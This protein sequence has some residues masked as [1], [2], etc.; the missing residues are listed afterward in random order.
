V[1]NPAPVS[2]M[3]K[4]IVAGENPGLPT[5]P[6]WRGRRISRTRLRHGVMVFLLLLVSASWVANTGADWLQ[7]TGYALLAL[8]AVP[9]GSSARFT[10]AL[11]RT[12]LLLISVT[13]LISLLNGGMASKGNLLFI[14]NILIGLSCAYVIGARSLAFAETY[15]GIVLALAMVSLALFPLIFLTDSVLVQLPDMLIKPSSSE[16]TQ[17]R[18][19]YT[20]LG[21]S[22]F[23]TNQTPSEIWRNQ[24][25]FWEP[26]MFGFMLVIALAFS[27]VL[28]ESRRRRAVYV[29][30]IVMTFAPGAYALLLFYLGLWAFS[31]LRKGVLAALV[32]SGLF[33]T[34][35]LLFIPLLREVLLVLF[36][37]DIYTDNSIYI[38]ITDLWLPYVVA[39]Q[40]PFWGYS[41]MV[42]YQD[43]MAIAIERRMDGM[44]NSFGAYFYRYGY[45]WAA[46]MFGVIAGGVRRFGPELGLLLPVLLLGIMY[47][48]IGFSPLFLALVFVG[49]NSSQTLRQQIAARG[50]QQALAENRQGSG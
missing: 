14:I 15:N 25:I 24:S 16:I 39:L 32:L 23:S 42:P 13:V 37:R 34:L 8:I 30:G 3:V 41:S 47:E 19:F 11:L 6:V 5:Q 1:S 33:A 50:G 38:R 4:G 44:T 9:L 22:Y 48:P 40:S 29:L 27:E 12:A 31:F 49:L 43:G 28:G 7:Y 46:F 10:P 36:N 18:R 17:D 21:L 45:I 35:A 20:I 2:Q 26:G